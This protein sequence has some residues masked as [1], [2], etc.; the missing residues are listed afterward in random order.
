MA[1]LHPEVEKMTEAG[2]TAEEWEHWGEH[3]NFV[4]FARRIA[5]LAVEKE[6][7]SNSE[8]AMKAN[9]ASFDDLH[10]CGNCNGTGYTV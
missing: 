10:I 3:G 4:P 1:D 7:Q 2:P 9:G 8:A 5:A 6:R